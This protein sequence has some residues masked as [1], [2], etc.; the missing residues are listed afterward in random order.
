MSAEGILSSSV[1]IICSDVIISAYIHNK[2]CTKNYYK[3]R[4]YISVQVH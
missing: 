1:A 2:H 4:V 3:G